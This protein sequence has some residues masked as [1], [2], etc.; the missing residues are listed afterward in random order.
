[1]KLYLDNLLA[2]GSNSE[3]R[4]AEMVEYLVVYHLSSVMDKYLRSELKVETA[5]I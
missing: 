5:M 1:M 4:E 2:F 3:A